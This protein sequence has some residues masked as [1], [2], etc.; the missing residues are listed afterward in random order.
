MVL[1]RLQY[2]YLLSHEADIVCTSTQHLMYRVNMFTLNLSGNRNWDCSNSE[3]MH[4]PCY[5]GFDKIGDGVWPGQ[6]N[7]V[8]TLPTMPSLLAILF[9]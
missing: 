1:N 7:F 6:G 5:P 8:K 2:T 4:S 3:G 9:C